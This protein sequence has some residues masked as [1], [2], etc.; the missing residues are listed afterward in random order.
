MA[1]PIWVTQDGSLGKIEEGIYYQLAV[2]ATDPDGEDIIFKVISGYLPPGLVLDA[3]G[4]LYGQPRLNYKL[5]GVP[6]NVN[7]DITSSFCIRASATDGKISDKTFSITVTG[8]DTPVI[9]NTSG[10][11]ATIL[12]GEYTEIQIDTIDDDNDV[13]V[14]N[15]IKGSIPEGMTLDTSTGKISGYPMP[16][17]SEYDADR[18]GWNAPGSAWEDDEWGLNR[19]VTT[20]KNY[21]FTLEVTDGKEKTDKIFSILVLSK[22]LLKADSTYHTVDD[23]QYVT[24]DMDT[25]QNPI[26]LTQDTDLGIYEHNNYFTY[27]FE[28]IDIFNSEPIGF[29]I[30]SGSLPPGLV[31]NT[32]TGWVYGYIPNQTISQT[33]YTV[34]VRAYKI[35]DPAQYSNTVELKLTV[36]SNLYSAVN[37]ISPSNLGTITTGELCNI[38]IESTNTANLT[39]NYYIYPRDNTGTSISIDSEYNNGAL[40]AENNGTVFNRALTVNGLKLVVAGAVGGQTAVPNEWAKK[41]A[42]TFELM[43][44]PNGAGINTTHQRNFIKTLKGDAGTKHAGIPTVQ[45]VAYGGGSTYTPNW[46]LDVNVASYAGL[47]AFNDSVAQK[48]MVWYKNINGNNPPT[49]RRDIEEIFEHIFHTIHAFGIPGAVPGSSDAVEMNPDIRI[50][51]EPSFDWKNTALH[52]A[53]KEA[54]D[55]GL[56]D[57][58]GYAPDWNTN[59]E[60][61][62]VAYTEY[63]YLV[64][65]SMWDMSVYWDGGSLAPEWDNSL[66]TPAGM[67]AN[68]P[69]GYA[70]FN[71]YF[72]PVL[73]KP[74]FATIESIFGENDTG[75]SG[76]VVDSVEYNNDYTIKGGQLPQGLVLQSN[77]LLIG[78]PS[79]EYTTYD[80]ND[81]TLDVSVREAGVRTGETTFDRDFNFTIVAESLNSEIRAQ[82]DFKVTVTSKNNKPY[83]SLYLK[84][85][86]TRDKYWQNIVLNTDIFPQ[87][88]IYRN[89]DP[90]FGIQLDARMLLISGLSAKS[91]TAIMTALDKNHYRKVLKFGKPQVAKSYL[92]D[93]T[94]E[95]EVVY[96]EIVD[97][98][99]TK[100]QETI[101]ASINLSQQINNEVIEYESKIPSDAIVYPNSLESMRSQLTT[102]I[103]LVS[104]SEALPNWMKNRQLDGSIIGWKPVVV[105]AYMKPGTGERALFNLKRRTDIVQR[106]ISFDVDRYILDNN[107]SK[108]YDNENEEYYNSTLTVFDSIV[109]TANTPVA[110]VDFA[111][112]VP[113]S[114]LHGKTTAQINASGG[115]DQIITAYQDKLIIFAKQEDYTG[116]TDEFEAVDGWLKTTTFYDSP[117]GF[118]ATDEEFDE[119][120]VIPGY[121]ENFADTEITNQRAGVWKFVK[122]TATQLWYLEFQSSIAVTNGD[123]IRVK[124]GFKYGGKVVEYSTTID[125]GN[126]VPEYNI[127]ESIE[128]TAATIFDN[129]N[130]KFINQIIVYQ[131]PDIGDTFLPFPKTN[132]WE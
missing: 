46:L 115:L 6:Y 24:A 110:T 125:S 76:Y 109:G 41:T 129:N 90:N 50:S 121:Q 17:V 49:Q 60:K 15:I 2:E 117:G 12:T 101:S 13:L 72:A 52:L 1:K 3:D 22:S 74:N 112:E 39:V 62:A 114:S 124:S 96:Y 42:R 48:D 105:L 93:K 91:S 92:L 20:H 100:N 7:K 21:E 28:A 106:N 30:E 123:Y 99:N 85:N 122:D 67:L 119:A 57:P 25:N 81:T 34:N 69:L 71:T 31:L 70:L 98:Q 128:E 89:S 29:E 80:S 43:T 4:N 83:E 10:S 79:F 14:Y 27:R 107:L 111:V 58:S 94:V 108:T 61:A 132:I 73:S 26:M 95:Y 35:S 65:W 120:E 51:M 33:E 55:A 126:T 66:K 88:D 16:Y 9:T 45:R 19:P 75:V 44:D 87:A 82:K 40:I 103:G 63:T 104:D 113:F 56:Y 97:D 23:T 59:P 18:L 68:N 36:V 64:N 47:Q 11:L 53:M 118:D 84:S 78:R 54:I 127:S 116:L 32:T 38:A 5:D 8:Q 77:G 37:W 130:T 86:L 102:A 131:A